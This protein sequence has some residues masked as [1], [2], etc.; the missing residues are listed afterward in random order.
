MMEMKI[1]CDVC[2]ENF[3]Y[4]VMQGLIENVLDYFID[5]TATGHKENGRYYCAKCWGLR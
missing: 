2:G 4:N 5:E 1:K 3:F